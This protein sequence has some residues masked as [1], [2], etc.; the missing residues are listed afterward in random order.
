M[1]TDLTIAQE[2]LTSWTNVPGVASLVI[3]RLGQKYRPGVRGWRKIRRRETT[4]AINGGLSGTLHRP[5]L[6]LGRYDTG[7]RPRALARPRH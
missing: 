2:W 4:E 3:R 1:T 7:G 5:Q 6:V